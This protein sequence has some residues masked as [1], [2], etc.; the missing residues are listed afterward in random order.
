MLNIQEHKLNQKDIDVI[1]K[2]MS[3]ENMINS[4]DKQ[5]IIDVANC[6]LGK[7][8]QMVC[9]ADVHFES[10][11][12]YLIEC[13]NDEES[14]AKLAASGNKKSLNETE[15]LRDLLLQLKL[16]SMQI[17]RLIKQWQSPS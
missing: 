3:P 5:K 4:W 2:Y 9:N 8:N 11:R 12:D 13:V 17:H 14:F 6:T 10:T 16:E 15:E 7:I 1:L